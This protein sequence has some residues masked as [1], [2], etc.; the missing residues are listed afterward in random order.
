MYFNLQICTNLNDWKR[1]GW[2]KLAKGFILGLVN[3]CREQQIYPLY[4]FCSQDKCTQHRGKVKALLFHVEIQSKSNS[5][6]N[7]LSC[8]KTAWLF[9]KLLKPQIILKTQTNSKTSKILLGLLLEHSS[10][11]KFTW[12]D[13]RHCKR[14]WGP[15]FTEL[16]KTTLHQETLHMAMKRLNPKK[17]APFPHSWGVAGLRYLHWIHT[18]YIVICFPRFTCNRRSTR[19]WIFSSPAVVKRSSN[20][21]GSREKETE[22]AI[23]SI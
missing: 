11:A 4:G 22:D 17:H 3:S 19:F 6:F 5:L 13:A 1:A 16:R 7:L 15:V 2:D 23:A 14:H 12:S 18:R 8:C 10:L 20:S 9:L 21:S